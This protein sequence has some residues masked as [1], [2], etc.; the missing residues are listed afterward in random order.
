ML[1]KVIQREWAA[2]IVPVPMKNGTVRICGDY[3]MTVNQCLK[4][5]QYPPPKPK[6]FLATF[7]NGK[8]FWNWNFHKRTNRHNWRRS[9]SSTKPSI[10]T[11]LYFSIPVYHLEWH[12][13]LPFFSEPRIRFP[14]ASQKFYV[15]QVPLESFSTLVSSLVSL[16]VSSHTFDIKPEYSLIPRFFL[17]VLDGMPDTHCSVHALY[18]PDIWENRIF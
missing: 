4:V 8:H 11:W 6:D 13:Q 1:K 17:W 5:D 7:A 9:L 3:K 15:T 10:L 18:F 14:K 2:P 16:M 12:Q